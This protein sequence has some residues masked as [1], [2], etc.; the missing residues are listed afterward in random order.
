MKVL[1]HASAWL[2]GSAQGAS[3]LTRDLMLVAMAS[4]ALDSCLIN[5]GSTTCAALTVKPPPCRAS[6]ANG[7]DTPLATSPTTSRSDASYSATVSR[8]MRAASSE[9]LDVPS[10]KVTPGAPAP[11]L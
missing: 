4:A 5:T 9:L 1:A 7:A 3:S 8:R 6:G 2:A 10:G 11:G